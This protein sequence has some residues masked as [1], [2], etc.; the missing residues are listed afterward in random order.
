MVYNIVFGTYYKLEQRVCKPHG[1][2]QYS[3]LHRPRPQG[4]PGGHRRGVHVPPGRGAPQGGHGDHRL[5]H[6]QQ[7]HGGASARPGH[8][9]GHRP[10]GGERPGGGAGDPHRRRPRRK[11]RNRRRPRRRYP[12]VR[13]GPGLGRHHEGLQERP[14]H[15]GHPRQ[16]HHYLHVHPHHHG[17]PDGPHGDDRRHPAPAG[18]R[19]PGGPRGHHHPG[20]LRVLQLLPLLLPHRGGDPQHRGRSPGFLQGSGRRGALLPRLRRPGAGERRHCGQ[21][22]RR[23]HHAH[24]GGGGAARP[25]LRSGAG[26]R[27]RRQPRLEPGAALLRRGVP[28]G[29]VHPRGPAGARRAQRKERPGRRRRRHRPGGGAGGRL[30]G[31]GRLPGGGP[32]LRAQGHLP[33]GG[34]V[35]RLRPPPR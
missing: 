31:P 1:K 33:R 19:L 32:P 3:R 25:H 22:R 14:V 27:P 4:P 5:G 34:G 13:A 16:D 12:R 29:C 26:R 20:E 6:A 28:G 10:P 18:L 11:S 35:R 15:R 24:P 21:C 17:R 30:R 2:R 8:P 7:R 9:R 23:Q